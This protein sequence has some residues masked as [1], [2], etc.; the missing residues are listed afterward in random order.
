MRLPRR[1]PRDIYGERR[2]RRVVAVTTAKRA[3]KQ[4]ALW[5]IV[6][7]GTIAASASAYPGL[8]PT[9][10]SRT[11]MAR[12][13]EGNTAW[14]ALFGPLR[15]LDTVAGYTAYKTGMTVIIL[16]AIWGLLVAT[17]VLRGDEDAGRWELFLSGRTTR[18]RAAAQAALGLGVG[19]VAAWSATFLL[20]AATGASAKV[21]IGVG[22][23]LFFVTALLSAAAVFMA[24]G[25]FVSEIAAT[26]RDANLIGAGVLAA[27]YLI[28][29]VA[30]S[31][32]AIGWLR[33]ASPIGWIEQMQPL[34][35]SRPLAFAIVVVAVAVL[36]GASVRI[37]N[38]RDLGASALGSRDAAAPRTL[39]LGGQ[40]G[41]TIRLTRPVI[42]AWLAALTVTGFVFGLVAQAAGTALRGAQGLEEA[43]RRLGGTSSGAAS[44]LGFVFLVAAA[45]VAIAV[46]GQ[47]AAARNEEAAGHL[48]NLLVRPVARWRW[49]GVRLVVALAL[50]VVASVLAGVAAWVGA[51]SQHADV[52]LG[53]LVGA[54]LNV[55]PPALFVLGIGGLAFG[56]WPRGAI[57]IAYGLVVWSF[58]VEALSAAV[59]SNHWFRDTSPML[60]IAPVPA[61]DP[62]WTAAAW[63][64]GLGAF[65]ALLGMAAF[66]RRDVVGA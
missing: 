26:R 39:L 21:G 66:A 10:A 25:M 55:V 15:R 46:A 61:A 12:T 49:L 64:V 16:G 48:D 5:G 38:T 32:P 59:N 20:T 19:W 11:A 51:A 17:R 58:L 14:A 50:V 57:G 28:R 13:F 33:W 37:A 3:G 53:Q 18:E 60:H 27:A 63:L 7:G 8:F 56:V 36:V 45:L 40:A 2:A 1:R 52:S 4:G 65:A 9:A 23:S 24:V 41:L 54:G 47:I 6:F 22:S 42:I 34:T 62:N 29:M 30:D 35:G 31:D 44:Y 43:I